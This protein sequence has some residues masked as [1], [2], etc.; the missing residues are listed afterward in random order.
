MNVKAQASTLARIGECLAVIAD[1]APMTA[2]EKMR[3]RWLVAREYARNRRGA[4]FAQMDMF[5]NTMEAKA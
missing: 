2:K 1:P 5:K 4:Q 3:H